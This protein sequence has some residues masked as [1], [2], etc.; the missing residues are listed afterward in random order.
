[1][2]LSYRYEVK[3]PIPLNR[4]EIVKLWLNNHGL[5]FK[6]HHPP[7]WVNSLYLDM[8]NL[9][10]FEENLSGISKRKKI[11]IRWYHELTQAENATLEFKHRQ[12]GKGYKIS[13]QTDLD[14]SQQPFHWPKVLKQCYADLPAEGKIKWG[15]EQYPVLICRYLREYYLSS[16]KR[17][18]ATFDQN[19]AVFDQRFNTR[20]N[21][22]RSV[23]L[24]DYILLEL[25]CDDMYEQELSSLLATCPLRPSRHSKYVNGVRQ[26]IWT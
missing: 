12:A 21:L 2:S 7:R 9:A 15:N 24:G 3:I 10:S 17:I 14:L 6:P 4:Y 22:T 16:C 8:Q 23:P 11:R 20:V 19:I 26:L 25:K 13:Y 18:R 5:L 1:M